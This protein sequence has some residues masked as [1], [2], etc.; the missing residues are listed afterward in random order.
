MKM[1]WAAAICLLL[2]LAA[3]SPVYATEPGTPGFYD[4][5]TG[6]G[7]LIEPLSPSGGPVEAESRDVD[8]DGTENVF[9]P[10]SSALRVTVFN[11]AAN[12]SYLLLICEAGGETVFYA[13]QAR[14]GGQLVFSIAF[15]LPEAQTDLLLRIGSDGE[16]F[17]AVTVPLA[18][19]P[20]AAGGR[21]PEE[22]P[23]EEQLPEEQPTEEQPPAEQIQ[24]EQPQ[25]DQV[26]AAW[27][28]C[29]RD[30][31]CPLQRFTD[32]DCGMWYHDGIHYALDEGILNGFDGG[33]FAPGSATSRAM[34]VTML[35]RMAGKPTNG[36]VVF[37]DVSDGLWYTEAVSWAASAQLV[38][39][40]GDQRFGPDDPV[41]REQ[42]A[43][44]LYR[45]IQSAGGGFREAWS[46]DADFADFPDVADWAYEAMCWM[47]MNGILQGTENRMLMPKETATR[48]Q[49]ATILMRL[50]EQK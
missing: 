15:S 19:T 32:L 23:P 11:T 2:F 34:L 8:C 38:A 28:A 47:T 22:Q 45:Y 39:G 12:R 42:L 49:V 36:D 46:Y 29:P 13:D 24:G 5:G 44:I 43:T 17:A 4:I 6:Q 1:R 33:I 16:G 31:S 41:T 26:P 10:G 20:A 27:S 25:E 7:V 37:T 14:G 3:G 30:K 35:W 9:Y 40:Y 48:A 18:Y 21:P 50:Y